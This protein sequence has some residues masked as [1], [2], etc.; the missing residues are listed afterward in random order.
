MNKSTFAVR[1]KESVLTF[2][3]DLLRNNKHRKLDTENYPD[4][5]TIVFFAKNAPR[6]SWHYYGYTRAVHSHKEKTKSNEQ[7]ISLFNGQILGLNAVEV[8]QEIF[9]LIGLE[10]SETRVKVANIIH[11][12]RPGII[13]SNPETKVLTLF[14]SWIELTK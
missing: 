3:G 6:E 12:I 1:D 5:R 11:G 4:L 9:K 10:A 14:V 7:N 2:F 13:Q 8:S